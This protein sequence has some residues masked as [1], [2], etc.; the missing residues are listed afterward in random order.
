MTNYEN[1]TENRLREELKKLK[2][3]RTTGNLTAADARAMR[4]IRRCLNEIESELESRPR[5]SVYAMPQP[6]RQEQQDA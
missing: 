4:E 2:A 1:W 5:R 6:R 3:N